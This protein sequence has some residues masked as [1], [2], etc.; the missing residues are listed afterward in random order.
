[1]KGLIMID[2]LNSSVIN[3][4]DGNVVI[5]PNI[6]HNLILVCIN[7]ESLQLP[8]KSYII[9]CD[10]N[11]NF[12]YRQNGYVDYNGVSHFNEQDWY[13]VTK[14]VEVINVFS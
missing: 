3:I 1:M 13:V 2:I 8:S 10:K 5:T 7:N 11:T 6:K 14:K 9:I 12:L 4:I